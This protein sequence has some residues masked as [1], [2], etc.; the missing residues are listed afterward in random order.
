MVV[1]DPPTPVGG[2]AAFAD[3]LGSVLKY[4]KAAKEKGLQGTVFVEFVVRPRW[5]DVG[6]QDC[7]RS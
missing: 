2:Y 1:S 3:E 6:L 4:P 5:Y 7:K